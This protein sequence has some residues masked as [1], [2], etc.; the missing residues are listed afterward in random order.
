MTHHTI[1]EELQGRVKKWAEYSWNR[2]V[3]LHYILHNRLSLRSDHYTSKTTRL[4]HKIKSIKM[5]N[6]DGRNIVHALLF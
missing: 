2:L 4:G 6:L 5:S 3:S 1:P